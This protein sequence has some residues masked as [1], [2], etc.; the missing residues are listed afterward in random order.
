[1]MARLGDR[2]RGIG[3]PSG[4]LAPSTLLHKAPEV[5]HLE[6]PQPPSANRYWRKFRNRIVRSAA[7]SSYQEAVWML[8]SRY[9]CGDG[10]VIFPVEDLTLTLRW[11]R[12]RGQNNQ[13]QGDLDNYLKV[14]LDALQGSLYTNDR[15]IVELHLYRMP[16]ERDERFGRV[17]LDVTER[18]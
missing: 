3:E 1:M 15:Q 8:A 18:R 10:P 16:D 7:A 13:F 12:R 11:W 4:G 14:L 9:R 2:E 5:V 6:L 17:V